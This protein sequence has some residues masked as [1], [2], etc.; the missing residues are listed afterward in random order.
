MS[1]AIEVLRLSHIVVPWLVVARRL[2][3]GQP[4]FWE[5][6]SPELPPSVDVTVAMTESPQDARATKKSRKKNKKKK[7]QLAPAETKAALQEPPTPRAPAPPKPEHHTLYCSACGAPVPLA[8]AP[9]RC[10]YCAV[11]VVPPPEIG[12]AY[13]RIVWAKRALELAERAWKRAVLWN[14]PLWVILFALAIV[15]WSGSYF[16]LVIEGSA[17]RSTL[18]WTKLDHIVLAASAPSGL[19]G[20]WTAVML[21]VNKEG[22]GRVIG[23]VPRASFNALPATSIACSHC[24][25][26]AQFAEGRFTTLCVYCGA[27]EARPSLAK[28]A[29]EQAQSIEKAAEF[30]MID[31]Y[32]AI[33]KRREK[34][35]MYVDIMALCVVAFI[36]IEMLRWIPFVGKV[37]AFFE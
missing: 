22:L 31:A 34:L 16:Y 30:S 23:K 36:A 8:D 5:G 17:Q 18:P 6:P 1:T 27:E 21:M 15:V 9:F 11:E 10:P 19:F 33:V 14:G 3:K 7:G 2:R 12:V 28:R 13:R 35:L 4:S 37:F 20:W 25:A 24:G 32:R 26:D 29:S